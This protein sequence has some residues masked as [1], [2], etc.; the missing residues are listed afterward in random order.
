MMFV[1]SSLTRSP[2]INRAFLPVDNSI[3]A[4][5][6]IVYGLAIAWDY[7]LYFGKSS[8]SGRDLISTEYLAPLIHFKYSGWEW[9]DV[10]PGF[11]MYYLFVG[12]ILLALMLAA[13][14]FYRLAAPCHFLGHAY[15][16]LCERTLFQNHYYLCVL[17]S[18]WMIFLPA[19]RTWSLDALLF[20]RIRSTVAP[21]WTVWILR[22]HIGL[23]YAFGGVMKLDID[24]LLGEPMR[25]MV[26]DVVT[27]GGL[28]GKIA[29][30][31]GVNATA[32]FL[33]WSGMLLDFLV[34]PGLMIA[35]PRWIR[36]FTLSAMV[37]FHLLNSQLFHIGIFPWLMLLSTPVFFD[38]A[39]PRR[40]W[41]W[42]FPTNASRS[43][44]TVPSEPSSI[45]PSRSHQ[46]TVC[47][48]LGCYAAFQI[49]FPFR[50]WL[51]PGRVNWT[52][53]GHQFAWQMMK[54]QKAVGAQFFVASKPGA[55]LVPINMNAYRM[56]PHQ[57]NAMGAN[58]DMTL[59]LAHT[60]A[61]LGRKQGMPDPVIKGIS[62]VSLNR[63]KPQLLYDPN[64]NLAKIPR[65][66]GHQSAIKPLEE[67]YPTEPFRLPPQEWPKLFPIKLENPPEPSP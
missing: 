62:I 40:V 52:E 55:P 17:I 18:F 46:V 32:L 44:K 59:Q 56:T 61:D 58:F 15:I 26:E 42:I 25:G 14:A 24:W 21:A 64:L 48:L 35:R 1:N 36:W 57:L 27:K 29:A 2:L 53:E 41:N 34:V 54:V 43:S 66:W 5:F 30:L 37:S 50:M 31:F 11:G 7:S 39:G 23:P 9:I 12:Q 19:H 45:I 33:S 3:L 8:W 47:S 60:L 20:P 28:L 16:F 13:G 51:Y 38:P 49:L 63:R 6:R 65:T 10:L 67:P 22:F 4:Y